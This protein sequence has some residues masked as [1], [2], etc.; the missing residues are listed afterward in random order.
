MWIKMLYK[1]YT[2]VTVI[3]YLV[4]T[5]SGPLY[6]FG[7]DYPLDE[8]IEVIS[9]FLTQIR[10][11]MNFVIFVIYKKE[12]QNLITSLYKN[13]YVH[14]TNLSAE[15]SSLVGEAIVHA[16][17]MTAAY[18]TLYTATAL[19]MILHPLTHKPTDL[20]QEEAL[21]RTE[22]PQRILPFKTWYPNWD[23]TKSPQY[24]IE[25][26][27]QATLAVLEAWCVASTD[28]FCV[29]LMIYVGCQFDLLGLVMKN[30][31][32]NLKS[33]FGE[34]KKSA[35]GSYPTQ[36]LALN[37]AMLPVIPEENAGKNQDVV[38]DSD[39][40]RASH[41]SSLQDKGVHSGREEGCRLPYKTKSCKKAEIN[42]MTY[43]K[44]C[45]KHHQSV[46]T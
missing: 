5:A 30:M 23:T 35:D 40:F 34:S 38:N 25:Y 44:D 14:D 20:D 16:R 11:C 46:L 27:A 45:I 6:I 43:I 33:G 39:R 32:R 2:S 17:K 24:E 12:I 18:F 13:F 3:L 9:I 19:S 22:G 8:G 7:R 31:N 36:I 4:L 1:G 10:S 29:T 26:F 15:E 41:E 21:N 42:T 37:N 28:T